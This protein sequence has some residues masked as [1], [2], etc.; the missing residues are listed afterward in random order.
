MPLLSLLLLLVCMFCMWTRAFNKFF[1]GWQQ[2]RK[3]SRIG[4]E[5][6]TC[7]K[8]RRHQSQLVNCLLGSSQLCFKHSVNISY[9]LIPDWDEKK[10]DLHVCCV[11]YEEDI[12]HLIS[13]LK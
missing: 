9:N 12:R 6:D 1:S 4:N 13:F 11:E 8:R 10:N 7:E 2:G 5:R 3:T